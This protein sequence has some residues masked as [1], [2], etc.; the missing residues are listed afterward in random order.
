VLSPSVEHRG[1]VMLGHRKNQS[2]QGALTICQVQR[3]GHVRAL[4]KPEQ[5]R[6]THHLLSTEGGFS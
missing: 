4:E 2:V 3:E 6:G 5:V 1:R